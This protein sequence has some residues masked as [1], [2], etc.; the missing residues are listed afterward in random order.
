MKKYRNLTIILLVTL[1]SLSVFYVNLA[2]SSSNLPDFYIKQTNG[3]TKLFDTLTLEAIYEDSVFSEEVEITKEGSL[4]DSELSFF[5]KLDYW[6]KRKDTTELKDL[7]DQYSSFMRGKTSKTQ[8][9]IDTNQV[10]YVDS[11]FDDSLFNPEIYNFRLKIDQLNK[12]TEDTN[13]FEV[14][15]PNLEP[16][17]FIEVLDTQIIMDELRVMTLSNSMNEDEIYKLHEYTIDLK[18]QKLVDDN[19]IFI[20][21][22]P[23]GQQS[24][25][26][27]GLN[28]INPTQANPNFIFQLSNSIIDEEEGSSQTVS[29][30]LYA[31]NYKT[32]KTDPLKLPADL[33]NQLLHAEE[34]YLAYDN[35]SL[36]ASNIKA[37]SKNK[38]VNMIRY[39][40]ENQKIAKDY[41]LPFELSTYE[42]DIE[43][44]QNKIILTYRGDHKQP[45]IKIY[46]LEDGKSIFEGTIDMK[47]KIPEVNY[48][49]FGIYQ[50]NGL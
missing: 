20:T 40:F 30:D 50:V 41:T 22:K 11:V 23:T 26:L 38:T 8:L 34:S 27:E 32:G 29:S 48:E 6:K 33:M 18:K 44:Y 42:H 9:Y 16:T 2:S 13:S 47:N 10:I 35:G 43:L 4:Y 12:K 37:D 45:F 39:D 5:E 7:T 3:D 25:Y 24:Y 17:E 1:L 31:Y 14:K 46:N 36:Y 49:D 28:D 15:I 21:E 19:S